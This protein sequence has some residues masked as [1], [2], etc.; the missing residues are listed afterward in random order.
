MAKPTPTYLRLFPE[1]R[2]LAESPPVDCL[3]SLCA[4]FSA[5]TGYLFGPVEQAEEAIEAEL[6]WSAPVNP[7]GGASPGPLRFGLREDS[8]RREPVCSSQSAIELAATV[9]RWVNRALSAEQA[10]EQREAELAAGVPLVPH[11]DEKQHL[12]E[13]LQA[14]LKAGAEAVG[15]QAAALYLLDDA[16]TELKLRAA[17]QLPVERL[18]APA[19]PLAQAVAD[20]AAMAGQAVVLEDAS[21]FVY[22]NPPERCGAAVCVPLSSPTVILGTLWLFSPAPRPFSDGEVSLA[23]MTAGRLCAD[24]EREVLL[25]EAVTAAALKRQL[26][27]AEQVQRSQLP[28]VPPLAA[29]WLMA[30]W[31]RPADRIAGEFYDWFAV[32]EDAL[33]VALGGGP[34]SGLDAA[35]AAQ[36]AR[37]SLRARAGY[38]SDPAALL[39]AVNQ[40][41]WRGSA[42]DAASGMVCG[43]FEPERNRVRLASAGRALALLITPSGWRQVTVPALLL[44]LDPDSRFDGGQTLLNPGDALVLVGEGLVDTLDHA[45][46]PLVGS[47]LAERLM[48]C[49]A[50]PAVGLV[51]EIRGYVESRAAASRSDHAVLVLKRTGVA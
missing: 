36:A 51:E 28:Q 16:T 33:A 12:A 9:A 11:R 50:L 39:A 24:L 46:R 22:W 5:A 43:V 38:V 10:L 40:D 32:G 15:C 19:R 2:E 13:R 3:A 45:G 14:V 6:M 47:A 37:A 21:D 31:L 48:A 17:W 34:R 27:A 42:G 29:G 25:T 26:D 20:V 30:G 7:G 4:S 8:L 41:L 35:L 23:E 49:L 44:G 1:R 18:T